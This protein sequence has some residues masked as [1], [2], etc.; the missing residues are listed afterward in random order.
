MKGDSLEATSTF[1]N[2][3]HFYKWPTHG[4]EALDIEGC[5]MQ[6]QQSK[7]LQ[8]CAMIVRYMASMAPVMSLDSLVFCY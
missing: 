6:S 7:L 5:G 1:M 2:Y 8:L 4:F 3:A